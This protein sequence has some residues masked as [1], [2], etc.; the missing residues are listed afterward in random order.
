MSMGGRAGGLR[1]AWMAWMAST[2]L[3][4]L[5]TTSLSAEEDKL[6]YFVD[7]RGVQHY[8]N[9]QLDP[10]YQLITSSTRLTW[11][12]SPSVTEEDDAATGAS[13]DTELVEDDVDVSSQQNDK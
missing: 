1:M 7:E 5:L 3:G 12:T 8:S 6:Y 13:L 9:M 11:S 4:L 2:A 10:R